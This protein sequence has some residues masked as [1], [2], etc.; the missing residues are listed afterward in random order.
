MTNRAYP[1]LIFANVVNELMLPVPG[2]G[3]ARSL[4][5]VSPR[6]IWLAQENDIVVTPRPI[7]DQFKRYA[8]DILGVDPDTIATCSPE[9]DRLEPLATSVKRAGMV[10]QLRALAAERPGITI[11]A[12]AL[13]RPTVELAEALDVPFD[14]YD[15]RITP[16]LQR[17][18]YRLNTKSG[19]KQVAAELGLK[20]VPGMYCEGLDAVV[21]AVQTLLAT[22]DGVLV[23]FDRSSNGYGHIFI[24]ASDPSV[25]S[26]RSY[27]ADR[28]TAVAE[29]PHVF[30]VEVLMPF[31]SVPSVEMVVDAQGP[32]LLYLCDQ[33]CPNGSFS[34]MAAPPVQTPPEVERELLEIGQVFG[35]YLHR[36]GFRGVYDVDTGL[37]PDGTLYVSETNLRRTGGTY[38]DL[39]MRRLVSETYLDSH[40]W[41][42]DAR[43]GKGAR[44]FFGGW[45]AL[46]KAGIAFDRSA[47]EG[48]LLT[49]DTLQID[50]KWRYLVIARTAE[51]AAELESQ[52]ETIVSL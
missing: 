43:L 15:T 47:G 34:G 9:T 27:I 11:N 16:E 22:A 5:G 45:A 42:A 30:T 33:R 26:L 48:I 12:F 4:I 18:I 44:D 23:K 10:E 32:Y 49:A 1:Q 8:C 14:G 39:L 50:G 3:H 52:L 29:Q 21:D 35:N 40:V 6:K 2:P 17:E 28:L 25:D 41:W 46:Q 31:V 13:D 24:R 20:T 37:T 36:I 51:R 19:F 7:D 38:L